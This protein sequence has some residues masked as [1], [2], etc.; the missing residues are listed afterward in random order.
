M[1]TTYN[2]TAELL[3]AEL[4][5]G[6]TEIQFIPS[7]QRVELELTLARLT[8]ANV[9]KKGCDYTDDLVDIL[10]YGKNEALKQGQTY[11]TSY[12]HRG[13]SWGTKLGKYSCTKNAEE[14]KLYVSYMTWEDIRE[15]KRNF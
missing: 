13:F 1:N 4:V 10:K 9:N 11:V 5:T 15:A 6:E 2:T 3:P 14:N 12:G 7:P 8:E